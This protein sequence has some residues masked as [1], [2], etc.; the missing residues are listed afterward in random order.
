MPR[1]R[2]YADGACSNNNSKTKKRVAGSGVFTPSLN[3]GF[4]CEV[5]G[6]QTNQRAELTAILL[7]LSKTEG[8]IKI[9]TDSL[10]AINTVSKEWVA[11]NTLTLKGSALENPIL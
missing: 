2:V 1:L 9:K 7:A 4:F 6:E 10:Y 11:K 5:E 8:K 3:R